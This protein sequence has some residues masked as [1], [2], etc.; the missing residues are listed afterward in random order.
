[1]SPSGK[2]REAARVAALGL[3]LAGVAAAQDPPL[4]RVAT[5]PLPDVRGRIDHFD[6]DFAGGRLFMSALGND[7]V[8]VFALA[9]GRRLHTLRGLHEPQ[10]VTFAPRS[11]LLF[12]ANG[13]DG[14]VRIFSGSHYALQKTVPLGADADDTRYDAAH[15]Q[16]V[17]GFG[18][19]RHSGLAFLDAASGQLRAVVPLAAHP[20]SFQL[21]AAGDRI[22]VNLPEAGNLVAVVNAAQGRVEAS[23]RL[24]GARGNFPMALDEPGQRL[25]VITRDPAE[26]LVL[27]TASG[28]IVARMPCVARADDAW[29]DAARRRLY[30]TGGAGA[31][32]VI[33]RQD[34]DHYRALAPVA[35]PA[36]GRTSFFAPSLNRLYLGIWGRGGHAEELRIYAV[37]PASP[38]PAAP[39]ARPARRP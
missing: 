6:A 24:G 34:A 18:E 7:T 19:G 38:P 26:V 9:D 11:G 36:G 22:Y 30:V 31:I 32:S 3:L 15:R 27:N 23:W 35:T 21:Q 4:R 1:M 17:V 20:E 28:A 13:D 12:V 29:Y 37:S 33:A 14:M 10:G 5:V 25:F 2:L 8:E 39:R 16:V